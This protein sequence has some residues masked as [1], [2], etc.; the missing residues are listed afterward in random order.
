MIQRLPEISKQNLPVH[1]SIPQ[2]CQHGIVV[3][4]PQGFGVQDHMVLHRELPGNIQ[5]S[6]NLHQNNEGH[7]IDSQQDVL[8]L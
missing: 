8:V 1:L 7:N 3:P 5:Q 6:V 2:A 4:P